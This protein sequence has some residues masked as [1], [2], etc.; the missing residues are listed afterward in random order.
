MET[1]VHKLFFE[2]LQVAVGQLGCLSRGPSAEE[3]QELYNMARQ[4]YLTGIGYRGVERLFDYG[5]RTT[6]DLSIDW[7]ADAED[8]KEASA[9][10]LKRCALVQKRLTEKGIRSSVLMGP[11]A[12]RLYDETLRELRQP[13]GIDIYVSCDVKRAVRF[14][15][16]TGQ[17]HVR[18]D[19]ACVYLEKWEETPVRLYYKPGMLMGPIGDRRLKQWVRRNGDGM[20]QI[21]DGLTVP[22]QLMNL[23]YILMDIHRSLMKGS[24][25]MAQMMDCY[26]LLRDMD[27]NF[28]TFKDGVTMDQVLCTL[29]I[30][31]FSRGVMWLLQESL[32]LERRLMPCEPLEPEGRFVLS[33]VIDGRHL[34]SILRQHPM[35]FLWSLL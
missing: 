33:E 22:S 28:G 7:M 14:V 12:G 23:I 19:E 4:Q 10:A 13:R 30:R 21:A 3:W 26:F 27:G 15:Q 11:A 18:H 16:L 29:D 34:L 1:Q 2:L 35:D 20:F 31:R 5:L 17:Q 32:Q 6:Q 25:T 24:A 9:K 8:I